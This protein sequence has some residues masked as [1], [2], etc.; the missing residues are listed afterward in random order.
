MAGSETFDEQWQAGVREVHGVFGNLSAEQLLRLRD[1]T[2]ELKA[3]KAEMQSLVAA[4]GAGSHCA[5]CGGECCVAGKYHF[6]KVDLLVYLVDAAPLFEPLFDNGLC[7]YLAPHGCLIPADYRPFNCITFNC[8]RIEDLLPDDD[9]A[10]FYAGERE[11]RRC[12]GEIRS[13]FPDHSMHG[14]VLADFPA[15]HP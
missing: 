5:D 14:A 13:L 9:L 2:V 6:S 7:P 15:K 12:Y 1:L 11:L 8:E 4:I 3:L 10:A